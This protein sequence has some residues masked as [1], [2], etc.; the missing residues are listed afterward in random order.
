[1]STH[2]EAPSQRRPSQE[3]TSPRPRPLSSSFYAPIDHSIPARQSTLHR[4]PQHIFPSKKNQLDSDLQVPYAFSHP[5]A[6]F[7]WTE[8]DALEN[9]KLNIWVQPPCLN[10]ELE[11][12]HESRQCDRYAKQEDSEGQILCCTRCKRKGDE[13][14]CIEQL[15]IRADG[16]F[17]VIYNA[18]LDQWRGEE[19]ELRRK[20]LVWWVPI[21]LEYGDAVRKAEIVEE[22]TRRDAR[23]ELRSA[24][25]KR[26]EITWRTIKQMNPVQGGLSFGR[27][28]DSS[29]KVSLKDLEDAE[30]L[31]ERTS[32]C[33]QMNQ[34]LVAEWND[35]EGDLRRE[36][37]Q[38]EEDAR[39]ERL[40]PDN[41][42]SVLELARW[43]LYWSERIRIERVQQYHKEIRE[44]GQEVADLHQAAWEA[45]DIISQACHFLDR[46]QHWV[47]YGVVEAE[48]IIF[49]KNDISKDD[50]GDSVI[51]TDLEELVPQM[52]Q[53]GA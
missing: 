23:P 16:N 42:R 29:S 39:V 45:K 15:E 13:W 9:H 2:H 12:E 47:Q 49:G 5:H 43:K 33:K 6:A 17:A 52:F 11:G 25:L 20:G 21:N 36:A 14:G 34:A 4:Y 38:A 30:A 32:F 18:V 41:K 27:I 31:E 51:V 8:A 22:W 3:E 26:G 37:A 19:Q 1:M 24:Q 28:F 40:Y 7:Y 53:A 44:L 10:C 50:E 46:K 35:E 48:A